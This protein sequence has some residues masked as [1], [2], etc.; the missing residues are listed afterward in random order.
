MSAPLP[1]SLRSL[2]PTAIL[3]AI[4]RDVAS[5]RAA[6]LDRRLANHAARRAVGTHASCPI[7]LVD[8]D[9][10]PVLRGESYYWTTRCTAH[11]R[12]CRYADG[13]HPRVA[14]PSAYGWAVQ[15]HA[16][17]LEVV[18]GRDWRP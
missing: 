6:I 11:V 13:E 17:T 4:A 15:Y 10:A 9:A 1:A 5:E 18:V 2:L 8:G 7:T 14:H 3:A 16:S 12:P